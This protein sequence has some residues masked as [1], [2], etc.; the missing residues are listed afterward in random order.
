MNTEVFVACGAGAGLQGHVY[1]TFEG[2]SR[3]YLAEERQAE[4]RLLEL[5]HEAVRSEQDAVRREAQ[6]L[7]V[8]LVMNAIP[9]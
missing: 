7:Q 4:A 8:L 2:I 9:L 6:K 5:R 3:V 1:T